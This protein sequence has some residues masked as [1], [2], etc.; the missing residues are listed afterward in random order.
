V[1]FSFV[2][3]RIDHY[4]V[5]TTLTIALAYGAYLTGEFFFGVSGVLSVVAAGLMVSYLSKPKQ[6]PTTKIFI[7]DF[8]EYA[9]FIANSLIFLMIGMQTKFQLLIQNATWIFWSILAV[10]IARILVVWMLRLFRHSSHPFS[11]SILLFWGGLRGA[12]SLAL[13]LSLSYDLQYRDQIQAMT[14]GVVLF[15]LLVQGS[16]LSPLIHRLGLVK[17]SHSRLHYEQQHARM[18]SLRSA[19]RRLE[20]LHDEGLI[21]LHVMES[22]LPIVNARIDQVQQQEKELFAAESPLRQEALADA[23][24]ESLRTQRST[25]VNLFQSN[26]I[27]E[28]VYGQMVGEI[29]AMLADKEKNW[30]EIQEIL[31]STNAEQKS[32]DES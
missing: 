5:E 14:F 30:P 6:S 7:S 9:A 26:V 18:T 28:E 13:A 32:E 27:S 24:N 16:T 1:V 23:W 8:W 4:I 12:V 15:S 21:P 11:W 22:L 3:N 29:D 25:L 17:Y 31:S 10:L 2:L 20:A 19:A